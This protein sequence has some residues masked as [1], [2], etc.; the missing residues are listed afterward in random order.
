MV[1]VLQVGDVCV[2][3]Y[4]YHLYMCGYV[5]LCICVWY[6][7][8]PAYVVCVWD[9]HVCFITH[10]P[11]LWWTCMHTVY[12]YMCGICGMCVFVWYMCG[13]PKIRLVQWLTVG[14]PPG[15]G[16]L[17]VISSLPLDTRQEFSRKGNSS[18]AL[19]LASSGLMDKPSEQWLT[20]WLK[21]ESIYRTEN[22]YTL[23]YRAFL[24][25][26]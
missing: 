21:L 3:W 11:C 17:W 2:I 6:D 9:V 22:T 10:E 24:I 16:V 8:C 23:P 19:H 12:M 15:S 25:I 1:F 7:L 5:C 13:I 18:S 26:R 14:H 20:E 4:L